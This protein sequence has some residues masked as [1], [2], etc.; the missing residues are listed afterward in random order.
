[1]SMRFGFIALL[2]GCCHSAPVQEAQLGPPQQP[3]TSVVGEGELQFGC[4]EPTECG[5]NRNCVDGVCSAFLEL[6]PLPPGERTAGPCWLGIARRAPQEPATQ[7]SECLSFDD[8]V[9]RCAQR[10]AIACFG[11]GRL[12]ELAGDAGAAVH[13]DAACALNL[14]EACRRADVA[15]SNGVCVP[16]QAT[17]VCR[18]SAG[19]PCGEVSLGCPGAVAFCGCGYGLSCEDG[20]CTSEHRAC[21]PMSPNDVCTGD[22]C[23]PVSAGCPGAVVHCQ[24][25][26]PRRCEDGQCR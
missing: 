5:P 15:R 18:S 3:T 26:G 10:D 22:V 7:S 14:L 6:T 11:A 25:S 24:C 2:L 4:A 9:A 17:Q 8:V 20:L 1:M 13:Y 16:R 19:R 21:D 12:A 23:G